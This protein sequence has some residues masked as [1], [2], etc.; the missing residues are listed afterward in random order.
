MFEIFDL[1]DL[2]YITLS[3]NKINRRNVKDR[4]D[5]FARRGITIS[6]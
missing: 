6:I 5:D 3:L 2:K 1:G 4:L